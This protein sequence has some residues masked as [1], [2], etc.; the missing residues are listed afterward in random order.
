MY[1]SESIS[2]T[3]NTYWGT[4][5]FTGGQATSD[6]GRYETFRRRDD[7]LSMTSTGEGTSYV[8][9]DGRLDYESNVD[10][11][12]E[13]GPDGAEV[14]LFSEPEPVPTEAEGGSDEEEEDP[15]F[16]AY[17]LDSSFVQLLPDV[18]VPRAGILVL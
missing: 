10:P 16:K 13:P 4:S 9:A 2:D 15:R 12:R 14:A 3:G 5:T 11:P 18:V 7:V 1:L 8:A 17:A 6:W